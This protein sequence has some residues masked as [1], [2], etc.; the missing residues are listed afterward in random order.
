MQSRS[1]LLGVRAATYE[2]RWR[3]IVQPVLEGKERKGVREEKATM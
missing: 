2:L 3:D 1:E